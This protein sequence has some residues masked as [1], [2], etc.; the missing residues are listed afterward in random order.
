[1]PKL[2]KRLWLIG[3]DEFDSLVV[4]LTRVKAW[5]SSLFG[6]LLALVERMESHNALRVDCSGE[7]RR[8]LAYCLPELLPHTVI[9][10]RRRVAVS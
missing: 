1:M 4:D 2:V 10:N 6:L 5:D 8:H 7:I 3:V 9:S